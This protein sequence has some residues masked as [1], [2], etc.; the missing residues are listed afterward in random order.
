M[1][2]AIGRLSHQKRPEAFLELK[3]SWEA[4]KLP[5]A[6]WVWVGDGDQRMKQALVT[7]GVH[8][9]GWLSQAETMDRLGGALALVHVARYEGLPVTVLEA[10]AIGVPVVAADIPALR[11]LEAIDRF[12][13]HE[14]ALIQMRALMD[15]AHRAARVHRALREVQLRYTSQQQREGLRDIYAAA[16]AARC[17]S[18]S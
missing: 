7:G 12:R 16:A 18:L 10:M 6:N 8:V 11:A 17:S 15:P 13:S 9:T 5:A 3:R 14:E 1:F 2:V 4:R